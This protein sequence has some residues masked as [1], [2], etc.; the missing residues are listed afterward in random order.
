M[1][2]MPL[3]MREIYLKKVPGIT[4]KHNTYWVLCK[5]LEVIWDWIHRAVPVGDGQ[6]LPP[7]TIAASFHLTHPVEGICDQ[8]GESPIQV[9]GGQTNLGYPSRDAMSLGRLLY[10]FFVTPPMYSSPATYTNGITCRNYIFQKFKYN[11]ILEDTT[12][13]S[14]N[15]LMFDISSNVY[16]HIDISVSSSLQGLR[17][18][19]KKYEPVSVSHVWPALSAAEGVTGL[20]NWD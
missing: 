18:R 5:L 16:T 7:L 17:Y 1:R 15:I 2:W 13:W 20:Y 10:M 8:V 19:Q 4:A 3:V 11:E 12:C 6:L 9:H 14:V